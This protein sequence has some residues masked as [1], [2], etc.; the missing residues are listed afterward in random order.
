MCK[1][2]ARCERSVI[3][4]TRFLFTLPF[5]FSS[6]PSCW[7]PVPFPTFDRTAKCSVIYV[8]DSGVLGPVLAKGVRTDLLCI[9]RMGPVHRVGSPTMYQPCNLTAGSAC[10]Q[11]ATSVCTT[12]GYCKGNE[13]YMYRGGCTDQSWHSINCAAEYLDGKKLCRK[14]KDSH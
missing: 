2:E 12:D 11:L 7:I 6:L 14:S 8:Y 10:C 4:I 3:N 9:C 1:D 13:Y 5:F